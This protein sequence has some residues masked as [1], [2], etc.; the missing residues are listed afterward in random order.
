MPGACS[1][2]I[3]Q[4]HATPLKGQH[5]T[6]TFFAELRDDGTNALMERLADNHP[7][8]FYTDDD[9]DEHLLRAR[10]TPWRALRWRWYD[11]EQLMRLRRALSATLAS[12]A[13]DTSRRMRLDER[14]HV[15]TVRAELAAMLERVDDAAT[16]HGLDA[17]VTRTLGLALAR[18][19]VGVAGVVAALHA[20]LQG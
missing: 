14:R 17:G 20:T 3:L 9:D 13:A 8:V 2:P 4:L 11:P 5:V 1:D 18:R 6:R 15:L 10:P 16:R 7:V 19:R 12:V